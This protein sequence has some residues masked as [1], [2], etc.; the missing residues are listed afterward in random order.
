MEMK[1][2]QA[3][4]EALQRYVQLEATLLQGLEA[5]KNTLLRVRGLY[6]YE[7]HIHMHKH[8][9]IHYCIRSCSE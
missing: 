5:N 4:K 8:R 2:I 1:R 7:W 3:V 6:S 9:H